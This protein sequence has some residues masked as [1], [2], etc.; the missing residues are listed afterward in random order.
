MKKN[1]S[2]YVKIK[3]INVAAYY[4]LPNLK[5]CLPSCYSSAK[6]LST[7]SLFKM[8]LLIPIPM[9]YGLKMLLVRPCSTNS[10]ENNKLSKQESF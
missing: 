5:E 6:N 3:V 7:N 10:S 1:N 4:L 9:Q 2:A 8:F